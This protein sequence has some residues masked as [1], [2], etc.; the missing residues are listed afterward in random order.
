MPSNL[1]NRLINDLAAVVFDT[2]LPYSPAETVTWTDADGTATDV[3]AIIGALE[4]D[5][6][7]A[8]DQTDRT[9][10]TDCQ[11]QAADVAGLALGDAITQADGT[12]WVVRRIIEHTASVLLVRLVQTRSVH[13]GRSR[14]EAPA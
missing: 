9:V 5:R 1:Q 12:D 6:E 7:P 4:V 14:R 3:P 2:S 8:G 10:G 11:F 13:R